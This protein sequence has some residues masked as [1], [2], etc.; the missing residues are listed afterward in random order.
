MFKN[1]PT[2]NR[3]I[4]GCFEQFWAQKQPILGSKWW[5]FFKNPRF[6][7]IYDFYEPKLDQKSWKIF[8]K[9][10]HKISNPKPSDFGL[11]RAILGSKTA[12]FRLKIMDFLKKS[13]VFDDLWLLRAQITSEIMQNI[14]PKKFKHFQP[15]ADRFWAQKQLI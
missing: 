2:Q 15:K 10:F 7:T 6:S 5:I 13:T 1:F 4:L 8:L 11:F 12:D 14:F 9:N 3:A